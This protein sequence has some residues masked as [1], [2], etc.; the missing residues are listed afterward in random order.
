MPPPAEVTAANH[1]GYPIPAPAKPPK[2]LFH[3]IFRYEGDGLIDQN[4][5]DVC[6]SCGLMQSDQKETKKASEKPAAA[7]SAGSNLF[8]FI[9]RYEGDGI[10]DNNVVDFFKAYLSAQN[11]QDEEGKKSEEQPPPTT[12]TASKPGNAPQR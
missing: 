8:Q 9:V 6:K 11:N 1:A 4:A 5:V 12:P 2:H 7:K 3:L 10:I